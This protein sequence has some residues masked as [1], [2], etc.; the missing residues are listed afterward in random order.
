M[1]ALDTSGKLNDFPIVVAISK[2]IDFPFKVVECD[3]LQ[4]WTFK[5]LYQQKKKWKFEFLSLLYYSGIE[6]FVKNNE[7]VLIDKDYDEASMRFM[8]K[9]IKELVKAWNNI[10]IKIEIVEGH[11]FIVMADLIAGAARR[12]LLSSIKVN[13]MGLA[14]KYFK[15]K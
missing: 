11:D 13:L 4:Y 7:R 2:V 3:A 6:G 9:R 8:E 1:L 5:S 15:E 12:G 10:D 14:I